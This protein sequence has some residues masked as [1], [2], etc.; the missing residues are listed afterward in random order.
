MQEQEEGNGE[1]QNNYIKRLKKSS[2][3]KKWKELNTNVFSIL[4]RFF[5]IIAMI[6]GYYLANYFL[7][8]GFLN[9]VSELT[10]ELTLLFSRRPTHSFLLLIQQ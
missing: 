9:E 7:S 6:E 8:A 5:V 4:L 1:D 2:K 3:R 10:S